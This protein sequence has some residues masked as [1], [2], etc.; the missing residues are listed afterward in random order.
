MNEMILP[1]IESPI[2]KSY[3]HHAYPL[4]ILL[5]DDGVLN[6]FYSNYIQLTY[7]PNDASYFDFYNTYFLHW[8]FFERQHILSETLSI[9]SISKNLFIKNA[10]KLGNYIYACVDEYYIPNREAYH[11]H[12][13]IHDIMVYGYS[14]KGN[15]YNIIGYNEKREY[16]KSL[17]NMEE[18]EKSNPEWI[19]L[20][21]IKSNN[22]YFC[23]LKLIKELVNDYLF[24]NKIGG[25]YSMSQISTNKF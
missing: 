3:H 19:N 8:E 25:K 23:D 14:D 16:K 2:I 11:K 24:P 13:Y 15:Y 6:W 5:N 1:L 4:G 10:I 21:K 17:V 22:K 18:F 9:N 20:L 12:H 7:K